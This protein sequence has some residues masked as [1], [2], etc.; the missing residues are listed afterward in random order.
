MALERAAAPLAPETIARLLA[1]AVC[2][3]ARL[4]RLLGLLHLVLERNVDVADAHAFKAR[5]RDH[6]VDAGERLERVAPWLDRDGGARLLMRLDALVVGLQQMADP[7]PAVREAIAGDARLAL[8]E[9][10]FDGELRR[11]LAELCKGV[12][13]GASTC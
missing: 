8:F 13:Q 10:D 7:A 12:K 5:L 4:P 1:D 3:D 9:I 6:V 2:A 11:T